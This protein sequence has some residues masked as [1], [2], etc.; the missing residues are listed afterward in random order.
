M[1]AVEDALEKLIMLKLT[2]YSNNVLAINLYHSLG[3]EAPVIHGVILTLADAT[4]MT[5]HQINLHHH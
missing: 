1:E 5:L 3:F 2:V 4:S